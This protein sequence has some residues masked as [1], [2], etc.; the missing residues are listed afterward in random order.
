MSPQDP[1]LELKDLKHKTDKTEEPIPMSVYRS[2][3]N[4]NMPAVLAV[5]FTLIVVTD[6]MV[7]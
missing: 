5:I 4:V 2:W 3:V 7:G 1:K 6:G